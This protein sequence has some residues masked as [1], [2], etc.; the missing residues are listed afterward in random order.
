LAHTTALEPMAVFTR[1]LVAVSAALPLSIFVFAAQFV[2]RGWPA[3]SAAAL[4]LMFWWLPF[5]IWGWGGYALLAGAVCALPLS[6]LSLDAVRARHPLWIAAAAACGL[7]VLLIHPSQA[8]G[9]LLITA[10]VAATLAASRLVPWWC[11][12]PFVA[13]LGLAGLG[14]GLAE[15][16]VGPIGSFLE[17]ARG[18]GVATSQD[19]RFHWPF[20][21]YFDYYGGTG[22]PMRGRI[23]IGLLYVI[24]GIF[25]L[26][27]KATR[28]L[29][30]LHVVLSLLIPLALHQTWLTALWY[31]T[32]ER[33]WYLQYASLP[34]L[35]ALGLGGVVLFLQRLFGKWCELPARQAVIW[36]TVL[37]L[38]LGGLNLRYFPWVSTRLSVFAHQEL[39]FT[40]HRALEDFAWIRDN[41][42]AGEILFNAPTDW[43]LSLAFTGHRT[44]FFSGGAAL[45][46]SA[47][48]IA[49][50]D[51]L[52]GPPAR[53]IDAV[54]GIRRE[55]IRYL[56]AASFDPTL[57]LTPAVPLSAQALKANPAVDLVYESTTAAVFQIRDVQARDLGVEDSE[58]LIFSGF[59]PVERDQRRKWRWTDGEGRIQVQGLGI[60]GPDCYLNLNV[61]AVGD[62]QVRLGDQPLESTSLGHRLPQPVMEQD[63]FEFAIHSPTF[64]PDGT[65]DSADPRTLGVMVMG[66]AVHCWGH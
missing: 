39:S 19:L 9:A 43:G 2:G 50:R 4:S 8:L 66:I 27:H 22:F 21:L 15:T 57:M 49:L 45:P 10:I 51:A 42:P 59:Y 11:P 28:P 58:T 31:H 25:A 52:N 13:A 61:P 41:V 37:A 54:R 12:L 63:V 60:S 6:R 24:G 65:S 48:W 18:V 38:F 62:Y 29:L 20:G 33:L 53:S 17:H 1:G 46:P 64:V 7:G 30:A 36:L 40:D 14:M 3:L 34:G 32:P 55:G 16:H 35:A 56:Y 23:G 26:L 5:Q 44:V 47:D